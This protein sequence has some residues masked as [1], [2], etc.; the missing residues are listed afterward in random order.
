[1][2]L[3]MYMWKR[4]RAGQYGAKKITVKVDTEMP[5]N[6]VKHEEFTV[7]SPN[8]CST[9]ILLPFAYWRKANA[10]HRWVL[11]QTEQME[12]TC[13]Q[14]YLSGNDLLALK[15]T[16]QK[17]IDDLSLAPELLPTQEG[18]FFGS[19]EYGEDYLVDL[20]DTLDYLKD[21][22]PDDEFIYQASW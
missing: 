14:I 9:Y 7:P 5:D 20:K 4:Q 13:Q 16:I 2:G 21:V 17:V 6:T 3:D 11:E 19:T 12:D 15:D 1:M 22:E 10:I 18:C 8:S